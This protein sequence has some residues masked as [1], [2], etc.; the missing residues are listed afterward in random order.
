MTV[1]AIEL[2]VNGGPCDDKQWPWLLG[3]YDNC[4]AASEIVFSPHDFFIAEGFR[5]HA[6]N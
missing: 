1:I 5:W 4:T 2:G 3:P 6:T